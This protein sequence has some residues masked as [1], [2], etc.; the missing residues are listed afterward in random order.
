MLIAMTRQCR[1]IWLDVKL[2]MLVETVR[3][4]E[5]NHCLR[6]IVVLMLGGLFGFGLEQELTLEPDL[7]F[8]LDGHVQKGGHVVEL[9]S[10]VR[11]QQRLVALASA[12]KHKTLAAKSMR[13]IEHLLDLSARMSKAMHVGTRRGAVHVAR[14]TKKIRRAPQ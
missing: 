13:H 6:V 2:E 9:L 4:Q 1:M 8:V 10:N 12:P 14:V 11:I 7:L 3:F 5:A